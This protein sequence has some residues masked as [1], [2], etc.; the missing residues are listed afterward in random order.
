MTIDLLHAAGAVAGALAVGYLTGRRS[1]RRQ[2][3]T[4]WGRSRAR[5]WRDVGIDDVDELLTPKT[6]EIPET[7]VLPVVEPRTEPTGAVVLRLPTQRMAQ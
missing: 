7:A 2:L 3:Q 5:S 1:Y 4:S 6:D